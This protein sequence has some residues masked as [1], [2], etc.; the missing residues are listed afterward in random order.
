MPYT[1]WFVGVIAA[2]FVYYG[3]SQLMTNLI[4]GT[5]TAEDVFLLTTVPLVLALIALAIPILVIGSR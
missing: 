1:K 5:I 4:T 2:L 3:A